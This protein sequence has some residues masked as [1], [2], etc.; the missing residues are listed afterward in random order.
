MDDLTA[1]EREMIMTFWHLG[2]FTVI[3]HR[4]VRWRIVL[5]DEEAGRTENGEGEDFGKAWDSLGDER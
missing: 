3:V 4:N 1:Q 5:A 2:R